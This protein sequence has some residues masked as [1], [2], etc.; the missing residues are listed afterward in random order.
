M[1]PRVDLEDDRAATQAGNVP[2]Q[3]LDVL[4]FQ[5][6][7]KANLAPDHG[8]LGTVHSPGGEADQTG[9]AKKL[10]RGQAGIA[11][12]PTSEPSTSPSSAFSAAGTAASFG[13]V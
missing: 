6:I 5:V 7:R 2:Q 1:L 9:G 13:S 4:G 3:R 12:D 11:H 8:L 10:G